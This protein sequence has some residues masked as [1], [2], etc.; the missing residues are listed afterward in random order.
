MSGSGLPCIVD[1]ALELH[2]VERQRAVAED[3]AVDLAAL[4]VLL[5]E[6]GH[7]VLVEHR[8]DARV[9]RGAVVDDRAGVDA[10][11]G[12]VERRLDDQRE[13]EVEVRG[14]SLRRR[15]RCR[16]GPAGRAA[17]SRAFACGFF[18]HS[19]SASGR[20]PVYG[21]PSSSNSAGT[22]CSCSVSSRK[23][24]TRFITTSGLSADRVE[25]VLEV[26]ADVDRSRRRGRALERALDQL[27]SPPRRSPTARHQ[28]R[29]PVRGASTIATKVCVHIVV[30]L[31]PEDQ[32]ARTLHRRQLLLT[33]TT[34][35]RD[36]DSETDAPGGVPHGWRA[37][38]S[39][40]RCALL[41]R[42]PD[43]TASANHCGELERGR[44]AVARILRETDRE[45][46]IDVGGQ[47]GEHRW[48]RRNAIDDVVQRRR[49]VLA[50]ER[51]VAG[52]R[53]IED[54]G[55]RV[56]VRAVVDILAARLLGRHVRRRADDVALG[57]RAGRPT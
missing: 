29:V 11:R 1:A 22:S 36:V 54:R 43:S 15:S 8:C 33:G 42:E 5:D 19:E 44:E 24:S 13:L 45:H 57:Q 2:L 51:R 21:M 23:N 28:R 6:R 9:E 20:L 12:V 39:S 49:D 41:G 34:S 46:A 31:V 18:W 32:D 17:A 26:V 40:A 25:Q 52:D 55:E 3:R 14:A 37:I 35:Q 48:L 53:A 7:L 30:D 16:A 56:D 27:A 38:S 47:L 4:D 10:A 50:R